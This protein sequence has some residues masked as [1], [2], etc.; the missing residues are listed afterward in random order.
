MLSNVENTC[1]HAWIALA[2]D[3]GLHLSS[4]STFQYH[5]LCPSLSCCLS[6]GNPSKVHFG[7]EPLVAPAAGTPGA[8]P[9]L[10][11]LLLSLTVEKF[12]P[13]HFS[14]VISS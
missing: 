7:P 2:V 8:L 3:R 5:H 12:D 13:R 10:M 1:K 11:L 14:A 9:R 6:P 4:G